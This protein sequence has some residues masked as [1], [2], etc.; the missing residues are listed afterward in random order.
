MRTFNGLSPRGFACGGLQARN[1]WEL[2]PAAL[3]RFRNEQS[4]NDSY[5]RLLPKLRPL[6]ALTE[7]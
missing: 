7:L 4:L 3:R 1:Y 6:R 2:R 5:D